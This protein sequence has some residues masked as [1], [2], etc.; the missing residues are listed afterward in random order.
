M[1]STFMGIA[2]DGYQ[3]NNAHTPAKSL[4]TFDVYPSSNTQDWLDLGSAFV[5]FRANSYN[6]I[7]FLAKDEVDNGWLLRKYGVRPIVMGKRRT[8]SYR[9]EMCSFHMLEKTPKKI[10]AHAFRRPLWPTKKKWGLQSFGPLSSLFQFSMSLKENLNASKPSEHPPEGG[11]MSKRLGGIKG[12]KNITFSWHL[13][14][15]PDGNSIGST[16]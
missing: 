15:F 3:Q 16:V 13:I 12:C 7:Q 14:G 9:T 11:N 1:H 10:C 8:K 4:Q 2:C 6:I 5:G